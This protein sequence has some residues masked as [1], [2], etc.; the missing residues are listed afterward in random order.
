MASHS[1]RCYVMYG[2][3]RHGVSSLPV[4]AVSLVL[5]CLCACSLSNLTRLVLRAR[6]SLRAISSSTGSK[7]LFS[8]VCV[9]AA[10]VISHSCRSL[11]ALSSL[12]AIFSSTGGTSLF[13]H[14]CVCAAPVFSL[15]SLFCAGSAVAFTG[16]R[17]CIHMSA[18]VQS[19]HSRRSLPSR[20]VNS[21]SQ[22]VRLVFA[23]LH[24][25]SLS[26]LLFFLRVRPSRRAISS[27][28]GGTS[29]FSHACVRA[30]SVILLISLFC[31]G[32]A[33]AACHLVVYSL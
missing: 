29:C 4:Q 28:T 8:P 24:A 2:F 10:S 12:R 32:S 17:S 23:C 15:T 18:C 13:S 7:S 19:S 27:S 14:A 6:P 3:G 5:A 25:C 26:H 30:A 22:A 31:P 11:R 16:G 1:C 9:L 20:L 21:S 33:I